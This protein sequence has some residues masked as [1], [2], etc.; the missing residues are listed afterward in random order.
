M[1]INTNK[2]I[3]STTAGFIRKLLRKIN[4]SIDAAGTAHI[5]G[6]TNMVRAKDLLTELVSLG[7]LD[8]DNERYSVSDHGKAF[9]AAKFADQLTRKAAEQLLDRVHY[10]VYTLN[11]M[12]QMTHYV[13]RLA[14]YGGILG[15]DQDIS[16]L[17]IVIDL[18]QRLE[19]T[20]VS[21]RAKKIQYGPE[22][23]FRTLRRLDKRLDVIEMASPAAGNVQYEEV[24]TTEIMRPE[25][26][27]KPTSETT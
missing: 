20:P 24:H 23:I 22:A 8:A 26:L 3:G 19:R 9:L 5:A 27:S 1:L 17:G 7:Y 11:N 14:I 12:S 18:Q 25:D 13:H 4:V 16:R 6:W 10:T 21:R 2:I 15:T